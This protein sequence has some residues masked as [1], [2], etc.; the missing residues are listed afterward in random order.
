MKFRFLSGIKF[1]FFSL[2]LL[3]GCK[4]DDTTTETPDPVATTKYVLMTMSEI[5]TAKPGFVSAFDTFPTT[6]ISNINTPNTLQGQGMGGWRPYK[7]WIF[8][9]FNSSNEKGIERLNI[10]SD[11]AVSGGSFIKTNNTINGS[12][13]FVI[14]D[15]TTGFYWDGDKPWE[16][17]TFNPTTLAN[18]GKIN[19]DF[20]TTLK[21]TDAGISFQGIGQHFLALKGGKLYA[22]ITYSKGTGATSG[23]FNDF[24]PDVYL[25]VIDVASGS[26][27]KTITIKETGSIT[28][29]NDNQMFSLDELG[30]LY[31]VCQGTTALGGK[32]KIVRIKAAETDIDAAW[33]LNRD[34]IDNIAGKFVSVFAKNGKIITLINN[35]ALVGGTTGNINTGEVWDFYSVDI[36]TKA[37]TKITGIPSV[38]N[39]GGALGAFELDDKILLRVNA[40]SASLNGYYELSGTAAQKLFGVT[41]GGA[42]TGLAKITL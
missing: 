38:T 30:D 22:D 32:S 37:L 16:I 35:T 12:G 17:Q 20:E 41:E 33:S 39:P 19:Y 29:I 6:D 4:D 26:Y 1:C 13:N 34:E 25:A 28:Y 5:T 18:T 15:E 9:M 23:M 7:N 24:F 10:T 3:A 14:Q 42:V 40:P 8:R 2:L 21:K 31:I 27:E 36:A 11:G